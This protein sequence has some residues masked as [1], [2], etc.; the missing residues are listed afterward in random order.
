MVTRATP[1]NVGAPDPA[2]KTSL[3]IEESDEDFDALAQEYDELPACYFNDVEYIDGSYVC[4]GSSELLHCVKGVWVRQGG[5]D[6][7]NP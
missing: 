6:E 2:M 7:G 5:C 1:V 4:S 3:I